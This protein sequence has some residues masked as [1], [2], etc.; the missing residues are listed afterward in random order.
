MHTATPALC[1]LKSGETKQRMLQVLA[2]LN[3]GMLTFSGLVV[4]IVLVINHWFVDWWIASRHYGEQYGGWALTAAILLCMVVRHWTATTAYTVFCFGHQRR[5]SLTNLGDG[6]ITAACCLA[7][8]LLWGPIGAPLGSVAGAF[9]VS[10]PFNLSLI[11]RDTDTSVM[12]LIWVML[13]GWLWRFALLTAAA[14]WLALHWSP[15]GMF[16]AGATAI[17][18]GIIYTLAMLPVL[19]RAPLGNYVRPLLTS[20]RDNVA[21]LGSSL[22]SRIRARHA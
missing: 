12:H 17:V 5:I 4:C 11:A 9:L 19:L 10:L 20:L 6:L 13:G 3:Q 18:A 14:A 2:A 8:T 22:S 7:G 16:E 15:K 21:A 1:E